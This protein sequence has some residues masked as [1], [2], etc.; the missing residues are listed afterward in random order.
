MTDGHAAPRPEGRTDEDAP[1]IP[2]R[3][4]YLRVDPDSI[5]AS[6]RELPR[7][8]LW[9]AEWHDSATGGKWQKV[10]YR[11]DGHKA[12]TTDARTWSPWAAVWD[13]YQRGGY[14]GVGI[15]IVP[16]LVG[17]D[18]DHCLDDAG[19]ISEPDIRDILSR[20]DS[21][22]EISASGTGLHVLASGKD[23]PFTGINTGSREAYNHGRYFTMTGHH[24]P[25]TPAEVLARPDEVAAYIAN[26]RPPRA[27][28]PPRTGDYPPPTEE[29]TRALLR[30]IDPQPGYDAW[31]RICW[32]VADGH[33]PDVAVRLIEEWSPGTAGEVAGKIAGRNGS[34]TYGTLVEVAKQHGYTP[35]PPAMLRISPAHL[36]ASDG[37]DIV[38]ALPEYARLDGGIAAGVR[39]DWLDPWIAAAQRLS[40]RTPRSLREASGLFA[41]NLA[42]ARRVYVKTGPKSVYPVLPLVFVG[43]STLTA[44][45][46]LLGALRDLVSDTGLLDLLLPSSFTPQALTAEL[47]LAVPADIRNGD[48][49]AQRWLER[50]RHAA[51]R[52]IVRDEIAGL[53]ED[54]RKDYNAGLLPLLLK[55]ADAPDYL[56]SELTIG[57]GH[58]EVHDVGVH[59]IGA[60]TPAS[61]RDHA[62]K[63]EHWANG[64]FGRL[65]LIDSDEDPHYAFWDEQADRIPGELV[66]RL[67][68]LYEALP[69]PHAEFVYKPSDNGDPKIVAARQVGYG[70]LQARMLPEAWDAYHQ[71][72]RALH[73]LAARPVASER[74]DPTYGRLPSMAVKVALALA[75][76][77]WAQH[78]TG[79]PTIGLGHWAA[80]QEITERWRH[81][82][83]RILAAALDSTAA[84]QAAHD[85]GRLGEALKKRGG[86]ASRGDM[87]QALNWTK[88][89]LDSAIEHAAGRVKQV[90]TKT[91]GR[92]SERLELVAATVHDPTTKGTKGF[93]GGDAENFSSNVTTKGTPV[94]PGN[95]FSAFSSTP[96]INGAAPPNEDPQADTV[97]VAW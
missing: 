60:T 48:G 5:P 13:V 40:P 7:W 6:L 58:V 23:S 4:A 85:V 43:R 82:A 30:A 27:E 93:A 73:T 74:L 54:C 35:P 57:R 21:Y 36:T 50:H 97:E 41:L 26:L 38:P 19:D 56:D 46:T 79:A 69:R 39:A 33:P 25:G 8:L 84:Q 16:P 64:L 12:S 63:P 90:N 17:L 86:S 88:E 72:D 62:A 81:S 65:A 83:H 44:K 2:P 11:P 37:L 42:I 22:T 95:G 77:E 47:A 59:L 78:T 15:A 28:K 68:R 67:R 51:Q 24:W 32:A 66:Q 31:L 1:S 91:G 10:P 92:T 76:M 80:A 52:G 9:R 89:K 20:I 96:A 61:L 53:L 18:F 71:Y 94:A 3:P 87:L 14:D 49:D 34:I 55:L 45:T 29:E 75:T 70:A